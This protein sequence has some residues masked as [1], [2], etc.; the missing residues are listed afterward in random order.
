MGKSS[1]NKF[2]ESN[3]ATWRYKGHVIK[4]NKESQRWDIYTRDEWS[5]GRGLRYPDW[6]G[7]TKQAVTNW[8]DCLSNPASISSK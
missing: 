2:D 4:W 8:L 5:Y 6:E 3:K 1:S 7:D